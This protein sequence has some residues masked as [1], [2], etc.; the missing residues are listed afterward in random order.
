MANYKDSQ[1]SPVF[2]Q[3]LDCCWQVRTAFVLLLVARVVCDG[4]VA[5][6]MQAFPTAFEFNDRLL[7]YIRQV[8]P[9]NESPLFVVNVTSRVCCSIYSVVFLEHFCATPNANDL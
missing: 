7:L 3:Y 9:F 2:V 8:F 5:Q 1:R 6:L 4:V